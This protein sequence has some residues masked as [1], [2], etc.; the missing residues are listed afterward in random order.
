MESD[1]RSGSKKVFLLPSTQNRLG[2]TSTL[3]Q[4]CVGENQS[5]WFSKLALTPSI[6]HS[7]YGG[8]LFGEREI[9]GILLRSS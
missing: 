6:K 5:Y 4:W 3:C 2:G 9:F 8:I 7:D 1:V